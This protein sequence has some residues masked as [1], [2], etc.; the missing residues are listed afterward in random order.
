MFRRLTCSHQEPPRKMASDL[1]A[2]SRDEQWKPVGH[3]L[4][5]VSG[6][7]HRPYRTTRASGM[8]GWRNGT[9]HPRMN[10]CLDS[11]VSAPDDAPPTTSD[12]TTCVE[13]GWHRSSIGRRN[14]VGRSIGGQAVQ[15]PGSRSRSPP[16]R[17]TGAGPATQRLGR[18]VTPGM[19][20]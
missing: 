10:L 15:S 17:P 18:Q 16:Q 2:I 14:S 3:R 8:N 11:C 12:P 1:A 5:C 6:R 20:V 7:Q 19:F 9:I 13:D 4:D